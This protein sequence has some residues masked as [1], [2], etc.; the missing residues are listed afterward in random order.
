[1]TRD[2][3]ERRQVWTYLVALLLGLLVGGTATRLAPLLELLVWPSL[4][5]LLYVTFTLTPLAHLPAAFRDLRF[6]AAVVLANFLLVPL[7]VLALLPLVPDHPALRLGV[8]LVLL[9]PCT[10]WFISFTQLGQ[11]DVRR[12]IAVTPLNLLLQF[13]LLPLYLWLFMEESMVGVLSAE[14]FLAAG[15]LFIGAPLLLAFL[16]QRW[17]ER[18]A[19]RRR[20]LSAFGLLP[21]PLL[22]IVVFLVAASNAAGVTGSGRLLL[23]YVLYLVGALAIGLLVARLFKLP[24][25][26]GRTLIFSVGTRNSFVVLPL[27]LALPPPWDVAAMV[28]VFQSLVELFGMAAFLW[29][30]P[31]TTGEAS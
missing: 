8:L 7:L 14:R 6:I 17:S 4:A 3:I 11:G 19:Q 2:T 18:K 23:T 12:A 22:A 13:L 15:L 21:V 10:D 20:L 31:R 1:M 24:A 25:A 27:A 9:V 30:V 16:T 28:I 26:Q 5:L 29:L